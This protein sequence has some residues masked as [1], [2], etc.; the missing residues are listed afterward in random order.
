M[1]TSLTEK[2]MVIQLKRCCTVGERL[3]STVFGPRHAQNY[4]HTTILQ[5]CGATALA[6]FVDH[7]LI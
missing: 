6:F 5:L 4:I 1:R 7:L 3:K 2:P